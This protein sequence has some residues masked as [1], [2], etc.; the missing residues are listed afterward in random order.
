[1]K[2]MLILPILAFVFFG[3]PMKAQTRQDKEGVCYTK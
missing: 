2:N 1:M 3:T